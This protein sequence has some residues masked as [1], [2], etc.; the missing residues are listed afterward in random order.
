[1]STLTKK[2]HILRA[3]EAEEV[4]NIYTTPEEVGGSPYLAIK[5][6]G[7]KGYVKLGSTT[8]ANATHLRVKNGNTTYAAWVNS[9]AL[10]PQVW[11][12]HGS[13][14]WFSNEW[15]NK[16]H[17]VHTDES[18]PVQ[19][20]VTCNGE[21]TDM[22]KMFMRCSNLTSIDLS[23]FNISNV[24]DMRAMFFYCASLIT[25]DLSNFD[26]SNVTNMY[27]MFAECSE[28]TTIKGVIDMKSCTSFRNM[29]SNCTKLT[30]VK[31]KNP[32]AG[33]KGAGLSSSQYTIVS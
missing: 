26:T 24:T 10:K 6:D 13:S 11:V 31:I 28:L 1:M 19:V 25:L 14:P 2:L 18:V 9:I 16:E 12:A 30:G 33:F 29:F 5:V 3:G 8:D 15:R 21:V 27:S 23:N 32:P 20:T 7:Q 17:V 4:C 22:T